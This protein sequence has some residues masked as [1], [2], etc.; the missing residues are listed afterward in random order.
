MI[1][2]LFPAHRVRQLSRL[3]R[4]AE[5]R[6]GAR[7]SIYSVADQVTTP[8]LMVFAAPYLLSKMGLEPFGVWMLVLA[9]TGSL[10]VFNFGLGDSTIKFISQYRGGND[11]RGME[12]TFRVNLM[13]GALLGVFAAAAMSGAAPFIARAILSA[14]TSTFVADVRAV[15]L[16]GLILALRSIESVLANTLRAFEDYAGASRISICVKIAIVGSSIALVGHGRGVGAILLATAICVA[17]GLAAYTIGVVRILPGISFKLEFDRSLWHRIS[18]FGMYSWLQSVAAMTFGQADKLIV[19]ALMGA[20]AA[21][22]YSICTQL[23]SMVHVIVGS[24]FG[25]L[26]PQFSRR[27][28]AGDLRGLT[29]VFRWAMALNWALTFA[30]AFP[31]I[32]GG[33]QILTLWLGRAFADQSSTLLA[34]LALGYA[35]LSINVVPYLMLLG[36]G[37]IRFAC[38][39]SIAA[40]AVSVAAAVL[41]IPRF[42]LV[43]AGLGRIAYG[44]V[45]TLCYFEAMRTLQRKRSTM[46]PVGALE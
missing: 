21:G 34:V 2:S 40:G 11:A 5:L 14:R 41:L 7:N 23:A 18:S 42:G 4:H 36:L 6:A 15:R 3:I 45:V 26:F 8:V 28:E 33:K 32:V 39:T 35:W 27:H 37:K 16:G 30:L 9:L 24:A 19:G 13:L 44:A 31:L 1:T 17:L 46:T 12:R 38:V 10:S 22:R 29:Q 43:G 25:F 20:A